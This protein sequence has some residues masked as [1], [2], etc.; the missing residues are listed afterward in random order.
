[1][2]K[3]RTAVDILADIERLH[4]EMEAAVDAEVDRAHAD[5]CRSIG[6]QCGIP[7]EVLRQDV[8]RHD[9]CL[10]SVMRRLS[11]EP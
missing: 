6:G 4:A 11:K 5:L 2:A 9:H 1:M 7:K 8:T 3:A 10:C